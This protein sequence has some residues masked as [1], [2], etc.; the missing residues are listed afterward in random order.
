L[1]QISLHS[2]IISFRPVLSLFALSPRSLS[3]P[4]FPSRTLPARVVQICGQRPSPQ[5]V[6]HATTSPHVDELSTDLLIQQAE[7]GSS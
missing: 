7:W 4:D 1:K 3:S 6:L 2:S 5:D